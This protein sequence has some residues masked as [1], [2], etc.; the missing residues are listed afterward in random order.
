MSSQ[1]P[2]RKLKKKASLYTVETPTSTGVFQNPSICA[3]SYQKHLVYWHLDGNIRVKI[4]RTCFQLHR[5]ILARQSKWFENQFNPR[6]PETISHNTEE[7]YDLTDLDIT[8][9]DFEELLRALDDTQ[10]VFSFHL[11]STFPSTY[12]QSFI[13]L[14]SKGSCHFRN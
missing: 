12:A 10:Y 2:P 9:D 8:A 4:G 6:E 5:S 1:R 11:L 13:V 7:P 3:K 14:A